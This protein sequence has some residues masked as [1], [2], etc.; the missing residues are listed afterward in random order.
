VATLPN[1]GFLAVHRS[2][3]R[4]PHAILNLEDVEIADVILGKEEGR[5]ALGGRRKMSSSILIWWIG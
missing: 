4:R 2:G 1:D 5:A 3:L